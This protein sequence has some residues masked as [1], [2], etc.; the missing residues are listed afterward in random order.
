MKKRNRHNQLNIRLSDK[1]LE[2]FNDKFKQSKSKNMTEFLVKC[3]LEKE[4]FVVDMDIFYKLY[5]LLSNQTNNINQIARKVNI[6]DEV[7]SKDVED[8]KVYKEKIAREL[9]NIQQMLQIKTN[10]EI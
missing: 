5:Y 6:F 7:T 10:K 2:L 9:F 1:E 4:I 3:V 8:L